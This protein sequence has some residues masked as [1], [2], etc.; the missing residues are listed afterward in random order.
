[1]GWAGLGLGGPGPEAG[2]AYSGTSSVTCSAAAATAAAAAAA[3]HLGPRIR[4]RENGT[5]R[6][7][8]QEGRRR[9]ERRH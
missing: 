4:V 9:K 6:G 8:L 3:S 7:A 1:M 5:F 2:R